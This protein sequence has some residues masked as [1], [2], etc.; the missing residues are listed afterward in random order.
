MTVTHK[1]SR[2]NANLLIVLILQY[3]LDL[4]ILAV[5]FLVVTGFRI[6]KI[7]RFWHGRPHI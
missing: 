7:Q 6:Y 3:T 2:L 4:A 1:A 5:A